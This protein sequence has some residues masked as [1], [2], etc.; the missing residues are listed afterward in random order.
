MKTEQQ[1]MK[2]ASRQYLM[3]RLPSHHRFALSS[4]FESGEPAVINALQGV[5]YSW[6]NAR[7]LYLAY[8]QQQKPKQKS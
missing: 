2:E 3:E 1:A 7:A 5:G 8:Q 4:C 6:T